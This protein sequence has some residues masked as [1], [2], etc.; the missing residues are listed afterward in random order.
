MTLMNF[1][2]INVLTTSIFFSIQIFENDGIK[3]EE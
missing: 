2:F 1:G 3:F